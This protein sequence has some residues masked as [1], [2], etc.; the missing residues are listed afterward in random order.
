M[1]AD[2]IDELADRG[3]LIPPAAA[4]GALRPLAH[5]PGALERFLSDRDG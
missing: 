2:R 1:L 4:R 5:R 3:V